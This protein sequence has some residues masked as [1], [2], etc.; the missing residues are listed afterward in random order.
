METLF[1]EVFIFTNDIGNFVGIRAT[2]IY[3]YKEA[4]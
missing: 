2:N 4:A 3:W 1:K